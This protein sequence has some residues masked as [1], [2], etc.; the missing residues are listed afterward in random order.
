[1]VSSFDPQNDSEFDAFVG[2]YRDMH[3]A[4]LGASGEEPEYFARYKLEVLRDI[5]GL[6]TRPLLDF[7]CGIGNLTR[8]LGDLHTEIHGY[9]PSS[10]SV[11]L[12]RE[13]AEFA[14]FHDDLGTIPRDTFGT[15]VLANVLHHVPPSER[16]GVI[17]G[18]VPLLGAGGRIVVF[19]HNRWNPLTVRAVRRCEFDVGVSLLSKPELGALLKHSG[20]EDVRSRF[21]VFFPSAL[22]S[23]RSL[24]PKMGFIPLG[25]QVCVSAR[26]D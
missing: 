2:S 19:E 24:E 6:E 10:R 7:G 18:I 4:V 5:L 20:L 3:A 9:D 14:T 15:V 17:A 13:R 23:L 1:M 21:V 26:R 22:R 12:A 11:E 16:P 25:A 8:L